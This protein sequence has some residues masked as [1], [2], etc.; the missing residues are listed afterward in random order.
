M[1][2]STTRTRPIWPFLPLTVPS[3]ADMDLA[4]V[5]RD[6]DRAAVALHRIAVGG[7]ELAGLVEAEMAVAGVAFAVRRLHHEE[8]LAVDREIERAHWWCRDGPRKGRAPTPVSCT[9]L[10][11]WA[12]LWPSAGGTVTTYSW[13]VGSSRWKAGGGDVGEVVRDHIH[14]AIGRDLMRQTDEQRIIHHGTFLVLG[15]PSRAPAM[16]EEN[17]AFGWIFHARADRSCAPCPARNSV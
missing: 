17:P 15:D 8:T 7:D 6:G 3:C 12:P 13:K 1:A 11:R 16:P 2:K 14:R 10:R 5:G 9:K 4:V